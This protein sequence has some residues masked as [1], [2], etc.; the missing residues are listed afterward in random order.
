[1]TAP[2]RADAA[3]AEVDAPAAAAAVVVTRVAARAVRRR[4]ARVAQPLHERLPAPVVR[5]VVP[6]PRRPY[7]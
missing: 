3:G 4:L 7:A 5:R 6:Y 1:M 2:G